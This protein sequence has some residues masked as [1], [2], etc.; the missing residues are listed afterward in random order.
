MDIKKVEKWH[1]LFEQSGTFKNQFKDL[2]FSAFDYDLLDDYG[3]TDFRIDLF[4]EIE[5]AYSG[6][7]SIFS[8]MGEKEA[9]FAFFPCVRFSKLFVWH[10][11]GNAKQY[12]EYGDLEKAE[13]FIKFQQEL[14]QYATLITK[15]VIVCMRKD[16]PLIIENPYSKEHYLTR[17]WPFLPGYVDNNRRDWGDYYE[18]PTQ[19]FF[20]NFDPLLTLDFDEPI[21]NYTKK[22]ILDMPQKQKSLISP[23]YAR[24]FIKTFLKEAKI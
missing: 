16:L 23:E 24:R 2:G 17:Y 19:F 12:K 4:E 18:K 3:E 7:V 15:L 14:T 9:V 22:A 8:K 21:A 20:F 13:N 11:Q 5:K 1:C 6:G 10:M